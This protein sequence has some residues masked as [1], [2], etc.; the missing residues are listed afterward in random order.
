MSLYRKKQDVI[1]KALKW[2]YGMMIFD[3]LTYFGSMDE[4]GVKKISRNKNSLII[5]TLEGEM[6]VSDGDYIIQGVRG[7]LYTCKADIFEETYELVDVGPSLS[8]LR[9]KGCDD[10]KT[11][12]THPI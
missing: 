4:I 5:H 7:E 12:Q 3:I 6:A 9:L 8:S 10:E 11:V 2:Q 1:V